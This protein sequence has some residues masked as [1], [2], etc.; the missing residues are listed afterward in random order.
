MKLEKVLLWIN[1]VLQRVSSVTFVDRRLLTN[2]KNTKNTIC[3][4]RR[5]VIS[6]YSTQSIEKKTV[7]LNNYLEETYKLVSFNIE[8][9]HGKCRDLA[10]LGEN[11]F[12]V[13]CPIT[14]DPNVNTQ[15]IVPWS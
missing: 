4:K 9:E 10:Y 14:N 7:T 2:L 12:K 1:I 15:I 5:Y 13:S 11:S 8:T 6:M 3:T